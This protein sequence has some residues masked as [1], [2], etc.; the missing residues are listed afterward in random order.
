MK[1]E[2]FEME[3]SCHLGCHGL[4]DVLEARRLWV[5]HA[6][7]PLLHLLVEEHQLAVHHLHP[8]V[9]GLP[10]APHGVSLVQLL[11]H[12]TNLLPLPPKITS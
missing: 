4:E 8:L 5:A 12:Q 2:F 7:H 3:R 11:P 10:H 6:P 9:V 1:E